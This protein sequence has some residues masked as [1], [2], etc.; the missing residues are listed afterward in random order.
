MKAAIWNAEGT[1]DITDRPVPE[2]TAGTVR[3][4]VESVG[5]C[6]T[7]LHFFRGEF[8]SPA[9]LLPGHE[10]SGVVDAV[11]EGVSVAVG[12]RVAVE[13]I[14]SCGQCAHCRTG[15]INR[16]VSRRLLGVNARGGMA[17][18]MS[19]PERTLYPLAEGTPAGLGAIAEPLAVCVRGLR[20]GGVAMGERVVVIGG[21][22]IGLICAWLARAAGA[23]DVV[24]VARHPH[25][26]T[27]AEGVGARVAADA[28]EAAGLV[29]GGADCVVETVG[30]TARTLVDATAIARPGGIIAMLGVFTGE[31]V[32]PGLDFSTKE[33]TMVGSN[34][35]GMGAVRSDFAVAVE[36]LGQH[37][38]ELEPLVTHTFALDEVNAAFDAAADKASGSLKVHIRS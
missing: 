29:S 24:V 18:F 19:A 14:L 37:W 15:Q 17:E 36:L 26:R 11:G 38:Q 13:P 1:L 9:G 28:K 33:L 31:A 20:L 12:T 16:C 10:V 6:G 8:P 4:R 2:P 32:L 21:G 23:A 25:Q 22:T 3:L 27:A 34:C 5:V 7:D 30:G 35:Y